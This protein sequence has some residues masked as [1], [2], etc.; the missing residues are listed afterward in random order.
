[1]PIWV[2]HGDED[3]VIPVSESDA[4]VAKLKALG[5]IVKYNRYEGVGHN[6]WDRAYANDSLYTWLA[7]QKLKK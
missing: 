1:M 5:R 6:S 7:Q 4:M 2:F 3:P